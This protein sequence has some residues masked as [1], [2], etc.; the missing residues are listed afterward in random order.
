M[1][2]DGSIEVVTPGID[3]QIGHLDGSRSLALDRAAAQLDV[4]NIAVTIRSD[5]I[6]A[7]WEKFAFITST[8]VLTCLVGHEIGPIAGAD[9]GIDLAHR[10]LAEVVAVAT[11]E[12]TPLSIAAQTGIDAIL[13]DPTSTFGPSMFRDMRAGRPIE[14]TVLQDLA[15]LAA[16]R[17]VSTPLLHASMVVIDVHNRRIAKDPTS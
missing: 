16:V 5:V 14:A 7:M 3:M 12:G 10:V 17:K 11:A 9:G 4:A 1:S 8:A 2:P 15:D 6:A 13:T